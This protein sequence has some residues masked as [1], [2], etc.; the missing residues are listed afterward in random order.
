MLQINYIR[1]NK[2]TVIERLAVKNFDATE[3][4]NQIIDIDESRRKMQN[5][6]DAVLNQSN[7]LAKQIGELMK[8]KKVTEA[9]DIKK[10]TTELKLKST[11]LYDDLNNLEKRLEGY[12]VLLP[13]LPH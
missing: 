8:D 1:E 2:N 6:L 7:V 4:V 13:N 9:N 12:L 3:I 10:K 5:E 11:L